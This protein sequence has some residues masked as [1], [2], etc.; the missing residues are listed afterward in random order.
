MA[1][2]S[3]ITPMSGGQTKFTIYLGLHSKRFPPMYRKFC[4]LCALC[5]CLCKQVIDMSIIELACCDSQAIVDILCPTEVVNVARKL[6]ILCKCDSCHLRSEF[7]SQTWCQWLA[8]K[9]F[10]LLPNDI[11]QLNA[12]PYLHLLW[13][14]TT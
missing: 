2:S 5:L 14:Q 7:A 4:L 6:S 9:C 11:T 12:G 8:I 10:I 13:C 3:K 1:T